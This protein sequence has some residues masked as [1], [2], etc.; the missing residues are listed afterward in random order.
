MG[1]ETVL[2][3]P[4]TESHGWRHP[5]EAAV[6]NDYA[7]W[8]NKIYSGESTTRNL[9]RGNCYPLRLWNLYSGHRNC[10]EQEDRAKER[11]RNRRSISGGRPSLPR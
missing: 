11:E 3:A 5:Y 9:G 4:R 6:R 10:D 2:P 1:C 7:T 8:P